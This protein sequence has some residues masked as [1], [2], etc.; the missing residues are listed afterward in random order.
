MGA[1]DMSLRIDAKE[2]AIVQSKK[3]TKAIFEGCN[4]VSLIKFEGVTSIESIDAESFN[5]LP[6]L[7]YIVYPGSLEKFSEIKIINPD[8]DR[9]FG[10]KFKHR[11][12][13]FLVTSGQDE[14]FNING[15]LV[16]LAPKK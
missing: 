16:N 5:D 2:I 6:N 9:M 13:V 11:K 14:V 3:I 4:K 7:K 10:L 12:Q 15:K 1:I 8:Q